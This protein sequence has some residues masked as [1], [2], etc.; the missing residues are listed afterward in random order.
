MYTN[1]IKRFM[2]K[3]NVITAR[4][5]DETSQRLDRL[6]KE[7]DR[8]RAWI[9]AAAVERFLREELEFVDAVLESEADVAAGRVNSHEQM[10]AM[11]GLSEEGRALQE[12]LSEIHPDVAQVVLTRIDRAACWLAENS[13]AAPATGYRDWRKLVVKRTSRVLIY[14]PDPS[15]IVVLHVH[16]ARSD[17]RKR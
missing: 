12:E 13:R 9:V 10:R 8:S 7:L 17:W 15:G 4:I 5:D 16:H 3:Q 11:L 6:A 14:R 1:A 2:A